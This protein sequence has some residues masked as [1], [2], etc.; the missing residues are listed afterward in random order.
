MSQVLYE[1]NP[2]VRDDHDNCDD[3][4]GCCAACGGH[5]NGECCYPNLGEEPEEGEGLAFDEDTHFD[6][7]YIDKVN[8]LEVSKPIWDKTRCLDCG[9]EATRDVRVPT[10][11]DPKIGQMVNT[12]NGEIWTGWINW[13]VCDGCG[14]ITH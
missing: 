6:L 4:A 1:D 13:V 7:D 14:K 8:G 10:A 9:E 5:D 3:D 11:Y 2:D 12:I